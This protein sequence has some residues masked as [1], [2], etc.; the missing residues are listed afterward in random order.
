[1]SQKISV[2]VPNDLWHW[3][4]VNTGSKP[5]SSVVVE[6]LSRLKSGS[7]Q[8]NQLWLG[9]GAV[10]AAGLALLYFRF[11]LRRKP[12]SKAGIARVSVGKFAGKHLQDGSTEIV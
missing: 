5:V 8:R 6:A 9:L 2:R 11:A 3:I 10:L 12:N 7:G 1:M 4:Q